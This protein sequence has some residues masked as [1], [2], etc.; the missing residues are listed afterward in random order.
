MPESRTPE[1]INA[2]LGEEWRSIAASSDFAELV[3]RRRQYTRRA[4]ALFLVSFATLV[5]PAV[6]AP[7][8]MARSLYRGLTAGYVLVLLVLVVMCGSTWLYQHWI[9]RHVDPLADRVRAAAQPTLATEESED[10]R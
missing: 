1:G 6:F 2:W 9:D 10:V 8:F 7:G 5:L 4:L 3:S